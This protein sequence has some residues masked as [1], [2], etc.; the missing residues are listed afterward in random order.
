VGEH[1]AIFPPHAVLRR[2]RRLLVALEHAEV[3]RMAGHNLSCE[4]SELV[5]QRI[6]GFLGMGSSKSPFGQE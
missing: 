5:N 2:A 3:V 6:Q 1:E 4:R